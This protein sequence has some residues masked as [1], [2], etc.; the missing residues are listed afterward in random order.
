MILRVLATWRLAQLLHGEDGPWEIFAKL[1]DLAGIRYNEYSRPV[2]DSQVGKMLL[3][4]WCTSIWAAIIIA[5]LDR[6]F[7]P[8]EILA[9][10]AGA[11]LI[12]QVNKN[13]SG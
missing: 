9:H 12:E 4:F 5:I 1:R 6:R 3:C 10:S 13:G 7:D 2:S 11:I 8:V